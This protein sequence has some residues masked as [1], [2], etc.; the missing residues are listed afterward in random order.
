[1]SCAHTVLMQVVGQLQQI[2]P[3]V[4]AKPALKK[5]GSI[6]D[7]K[8]GDAVSMDIDPQDVSIKPDPIPKGVQSYRKL[9]AVWRRLEIPFVPSEEAAGDA[10]S[11][12]S[13]GGFK[14]LDAELVA[15]MDKIGLTSTYWEIFQALTLERLSAGFMQA[16]SPLY[17]LYQRNIYSVKGSAKNNA[18]AFAK[19]VRHKFAECDMQAYIL[20]WL[21]TQDDVEKI[22]TQPKTR[23][24]WRKSWPSVMGML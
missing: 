21:E 6:R 7:N 3:A 13:K 12:D 8:A 9:P 20:F 4:P 15:W 18:K 10:A 22:L 2:R 23:E 24:K 16:K 19:R 1:M 5:P 17:P 14:K 11:P